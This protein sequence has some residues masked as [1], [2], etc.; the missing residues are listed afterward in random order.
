M[1]DAGNRLLIV[2]D[3]PELLEF[4]VNELQQ[5]GQQPKATQHPLTRHCSNLMDR[6]KAFCN[7]YRRVALELRAF[8]DNS[9]RS[10]L[11]GQR[12]REMVNE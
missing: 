11:H 1:G 4:L 12:R 7:P 8:S 2:D 3:D 10:L 6:I 5:E 9:C